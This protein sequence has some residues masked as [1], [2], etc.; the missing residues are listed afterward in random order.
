MFRVGGLGFALRFVEGGLVSDCRV[1]S[2][3]PSTLSSGYYILMLLAAHHPQSVGVVKMSR[4]ALIKG[5]LLQAWSVLKL[6]NYRTPADPLSTEAAPPSRVA[7][8]CPLAGVAAR[9][10]VRM[11]S[12]TS[13]DGCWSPSS[14]SSV[15]RSLYSCVY[16]LNATA[17]YAQRD[18]SDRYLG[19]NTAH[20]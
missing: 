11:A 17:A 12:S 10:R 1:S 18:C 8:A 4:L 6:N 20:T 15:G 13:I 7:C 14:R 2:L 16:C 19:G 9:H 3:I 5:I